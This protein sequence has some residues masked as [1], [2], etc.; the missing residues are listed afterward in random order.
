M[1]A[2]A[3]PDLIYLINMICVS[4]D[5]VEIQT[6]DRESVRHWLKRVDQEGSSWTV[7]RVERGKEAPDLIDITNEILNE[8]AADGS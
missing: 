5:Y 8:I 2:G 4:D 6:R 1:V 3:T 7:L